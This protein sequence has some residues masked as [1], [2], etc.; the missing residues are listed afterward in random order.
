MEINGKPELHRLCQAHIDA[1]LESIKELKAENERLVG[2][3]F[4][5]DKAMGAIGTDNGM[6]RERLTLTEAAWRET[7]R[8]CI[9]ALN[10]LEQAEKYIDDHACQHSTTCMGESAET[11][12]GIL[13]EIREAK[14]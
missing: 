3:I 6:L 12:L 1:A 8:A 14:G 11:R 2:V 4:D 13:T 10:A 7:N 9:A 5:R